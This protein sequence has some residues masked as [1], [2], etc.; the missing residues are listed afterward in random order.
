[1]TPEQIAREAAERLVP[2]VGPDN[3]WEEIY[4]KIRL[5]VEQSILIAA[6]LI[7][8]Q[9]VRDTGAVEALDEGDIIAMSTNGEYA[10][11]NLR[12]ISEEK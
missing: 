7:A 1:M 6:R 9:M 12:K 2:L 10:I 8:A 4:G 3:T 5:N 11:S